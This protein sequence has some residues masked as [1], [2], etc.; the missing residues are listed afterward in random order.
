MSTF[1]VGLETR[2]YTFEGIDAVKTW[3][4]GN[5]VQAT[6][7]KPKSYFSNT[8]ISN[9]IRDLLNTLTITYICSE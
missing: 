4:Q 1:K 3:L 2:L 6:L 9:C 7:G 5:V 8:S